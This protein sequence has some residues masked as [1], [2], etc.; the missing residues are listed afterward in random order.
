MI[1]DKIAIF[2]EEYINFCYET[3][4]SDA[5]NGH[6]TIAFHVPWHSGFRPKE[7]CRLRGGVLQPGELV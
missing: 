6:G 2:A 3:N 1:S 7:V 4:Y 5:E